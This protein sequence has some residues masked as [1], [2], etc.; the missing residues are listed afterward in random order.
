M[1]LLCSELRFSVRK[2]LRANGLGVEF[3]VSHLD[4]SSE[5]SLRHWFSN[6]VSNKQINQNVLLLRWAF[7][8]IRVR[9]QFTNRQIVSISQE[10]AIDLYDL[11]TVNRW[12][13]PCG[14]LSS[15]NTEWREWIRRGNLKVEKLSNLESLNSPLRL[16]SR[17]P[18]KISCFDS[19][20]Y[21][22]DS[23]LWLRTKRLQL[24]FSCR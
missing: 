7:P 18:L 10:T 6:E 22:S 17:S 4:A 11:I 8:A 13:S 12:Q 19:V 3:A 14:N 21:L 2:I 15:P 24:K 23:P 5:K 20:L 1:S 9:K 16:L